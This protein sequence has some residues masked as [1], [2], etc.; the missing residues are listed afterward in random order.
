MSY[1]LADKQLAARYS[2]SR[3]TIW[4]WVEDGI[5]PPP[6]QISPGTT[7]WNGEAIDQLDAEREQR[8]KEA[9]A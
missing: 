2:V 1:W 6:V 9:A 5:L 7:R 8:A 3:T 4:R